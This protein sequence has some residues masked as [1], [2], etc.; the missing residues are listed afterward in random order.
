MNVILC[1]DKKQSD[2]QAQLSPSEVQSWLRGSRSQLEASW[3]SLLRDS[4]TQSP[5]GPQAPHAAQKLGARYR[6]PHPLQTAAAIRVTEAG[7]V[8]RFT[9]TSRTG[10]VQ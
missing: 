8:G 3:L 10:P 9:T 7:M 2:P 4:G 1:Y 6:Q 5:A